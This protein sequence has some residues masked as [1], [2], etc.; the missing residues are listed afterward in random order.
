MKQSVLGSLWYRYIIRL[1]GERCVKNVFIDEEFI[2]FLGIWGE[3]GK[4]RS[5][6]CKDLDIS[7][8]IFFFK[9][10]RKMF[11]LLKGS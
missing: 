11:I 4:E 8:S 5:F 10:R 2:N 3:V 7:E 9:Y 1:E 6:K